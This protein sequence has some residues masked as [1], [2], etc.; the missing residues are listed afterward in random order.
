MDI[1]EEELYTFNNLAKF[2]TNDIDIDSHVWWSANCKQIPIL[3]KLSQV[4]LIS[5]PSIAENDR[6][7]R[8]GTRICVPYRVMLRGE[9][10]ELFDTLKH[11]KMNKKKHTSL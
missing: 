2:V 3:F 8:I 7:F 4:Y 6:L 5:T 9:T 11:R 10:I 1:I